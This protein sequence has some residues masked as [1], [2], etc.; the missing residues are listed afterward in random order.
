VF[1]VPNVT[2]KTCNVCG[3]VMLARNWIRHLER[4]H[5]NAA[6]AASTTAT[7][8]GQLE[9]VA[10]V[11]RASRRQ[12]SVD[13]VR[14]KHQ[15]RRCISLIYP[16]ACLELPTAVQ[17]SYV[18]HAMP[19][20]SPSDRS[21]CVTTVGLLMS[22]F[23]NELRFARSTMETRHF[24]KPRSKSVQ[25]CPEI[26][27]G[28]GARTQLVE[29]EIHRDPIIPDDASFIAD[30]ASLFSATENVELLESINA[31]DELPQLTG[32]D[33]ERNIPR[34]EQGDVIQPTE[35]S[36]VV[37]QSGKTKQLLQPAAASTAGLLVTGHRGAPAEKRTAAE[38]VVTSSLL[39]VE[40]NQQRRP[41]QSQAPAT[42][43]V[44]S[45]RATSPAARIK[46]WQHDAEKRGSPRPR[47]VRRS[48][49]SRSP[50]R[51]VHG[52]Q[53]RDPRRDRCSRSPRR[54]ERRLTPKSSPPRHF[55]YERG[56]DDARRDDHRPR[57]RELPDADDQ[58]MSE[59]FNFIKRRRE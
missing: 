51:E 21:I 26:E 56:R 38:A 59:I 15:L 22:K 1:K 55:Q 25:P 4:C 14:K 41:A 11:G 54:A 19:K 23:K 37:K 27:S 16:Y 8:G 53:R 42:H 34:A 9:Q 47:D 12:A 7:S 29:A 57:E 32:D 45:Q 36:A 3:E 2:K 40:T 24:C 58:L 46:S 6:G 18:K 52:Y 20:M 31:A 35:P 17:M 5:K 43:R 49:S 28:V 33:V 50:A 30:S 10:Q 39:A 48:S 13:A 44:T